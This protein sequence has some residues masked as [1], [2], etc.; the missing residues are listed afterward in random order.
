MEEEE[1][2]SKNHAAEGTL[3]RV[4]WVADCSRGF[5]LP[6]SSK[7]A[8]GFCAPAENKEEINFI[9]MTCFDMTKIR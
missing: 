1:E 6:D 7:R 5:W 2:R 8:L 4:G 3:Y 9:Y